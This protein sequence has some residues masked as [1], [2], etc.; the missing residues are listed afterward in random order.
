MKIA[1]YEKL[2]GEPHLKIGTRFYSL[3]NTEGV[4]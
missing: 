1:L 4:Q 2:G 3:G